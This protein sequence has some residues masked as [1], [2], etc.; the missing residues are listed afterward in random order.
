MLNC[1]V[2]GKKYSS[3]T[4]AKRQLTSAMTLTLSDDVVKVRTD[5]P[6][7]P[8]C[9]AFVLDWTRHLIIAAPLCVQTSC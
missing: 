2:K 4:L 5:D 3:L 1:C 6:A 8:V 7:G 9:P